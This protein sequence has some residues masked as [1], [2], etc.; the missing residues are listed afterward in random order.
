MSCIN[1]V[2][3][4]RFSLTGTGS[5]CG[6]QDSGLITHYLISERNGDNK[7]P[8]SVGHSILKDGRGAC[9][10]RIWNGSEYTKERDMPRF[11]ENFYHVITRKNIVTHGSDNYPY[12]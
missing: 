11:S 4:A 10:E 2:Q 12:A 3:D 9:A 5:T 1:E 8:L 7:N 6:S